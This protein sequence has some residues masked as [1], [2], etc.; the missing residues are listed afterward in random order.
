MTIL[1]RTVDGKTLGEE[2]RVEKSGFGRGWIIV[3][4]FTDLSANVTFRTK[5]E[6]VVAAAKHRYSVFSLAPETK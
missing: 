4:S 5:K 1:K 2:V 3:E 6:A